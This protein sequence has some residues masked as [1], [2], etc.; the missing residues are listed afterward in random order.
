MI[1]PSTIIVVGAVAAGPEAA[2]AVAEAVAAAGE[3]CGCS[4]NM[5]PAIDLPGRGAHC[6]L[7]EAYMH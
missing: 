4:G 2:A 6:A 7:A 3:C 1:G 5:H